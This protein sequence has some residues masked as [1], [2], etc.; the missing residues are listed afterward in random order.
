MSSGRYWGGFG[1]HQEQQYTSSGPMLV[2]Y[3]KVG[4]KCLILTT[5]KQTLTILLFPC[6][7]GGIE[8][9]SVFL[10]CSGA[11]GETPPAVHTSTGIIRIRQKSHFLVGKQ[12]RICAA[13]MLILC[14]SAGL[15]ENLLIE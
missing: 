10:I 4:L 1:D 8:C 3:A 14:F 13:H 5:I 2:K 15:K 9:S 6:K 7:T 12:W 11:V